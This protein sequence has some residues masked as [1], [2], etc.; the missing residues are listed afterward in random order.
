VAG[1]LENFLELWA[2]RRQLAPPRRDDEG[3]HF[4]VFDGEY[5]VALSQAGPSIILETQLAELPGRRDEAEEALKRLL[6]LQL[7]KARSE[8][9]VLSLAPDRDQLVLFR[10]LRSERLNLLGFDAALGEFVNATAF[11]LERLAPSDKSPVRAGPVT[12][13]ILYP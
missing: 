5:E 11:W 3:K 12:E 8:R 7:A 6:R 2:S 13:R 1:E 9:E 4:L 10:I